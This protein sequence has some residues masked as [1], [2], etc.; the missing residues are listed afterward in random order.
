VSPSPFVSSATPIA[1]KRE[2]KGNET[3]NETVSISG[4]D[5]FIEEK[6]ERRKRTQTETKEMKAGIYATLV[7]FATRRTAG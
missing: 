5:D 2:T 3:G 4:N 1:R 6:H 7:S